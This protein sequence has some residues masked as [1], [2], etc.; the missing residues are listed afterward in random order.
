MAWL[1]GEF[2]RLSGQAEK[3]CENVIKKGLWTAQRGTMLDM[4]PCILKNLPAICTKPKYKK[5]VS[6]IKYWSYP[7]PR[8]VRVLTT[9]QVLLI[10]VWG[11]GVTKVVLMIAMLRT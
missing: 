3:L 1:A 10:S 9:G 11:R 4:K 6:Y 8:R 5:P 2:S 7:R